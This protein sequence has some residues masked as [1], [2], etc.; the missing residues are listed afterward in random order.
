MEKAFFNAV[1]LVVPNSVYCPRED[2]FLLAECV[3]KEK[4]AGKSFLD[5][6][7]GTGIQGIAALEK[8]AKV[9]FADKNKEAAKAAQEN[10]KNA[11]YIDFTTRQ[12]DLFEKIGEKF[13]FIAFNPPYVQ[14]GEDEKPDERLT[15]GK[16]GRKLIE[17]FLKE[18]KGHLGKEGKI[19]L[20]CS[21]QDNFG[22]VEALMKK[23]GLEFRIAAKKNIFFE[24]LRVYSAS[25]DLKE[26]SKD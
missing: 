6:G 25:L 23:R 11:G 17:L 1:E 26:K 19:L 9:L 24:E 3:Q 12:S 21:S 8:G 10:A 16:S 22:K 14:Q 7:C 18:T 2:S 5:L 20:L 4:L 15:G 13:D